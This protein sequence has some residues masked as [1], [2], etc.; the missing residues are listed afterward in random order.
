MNTSRLTNT[1]FQ[2]PN[3]ATHLVHTAMLPF[4]PNCPVCGSAIALDETGIPTLSRAGPFS[5]P[6]GSMSASG[7]VIGGLMGAVLGGPG[8]ALLGALIGGAIGTANETKH[9]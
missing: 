9:E 8:G 4:Q 1:Y 2:C 7:A 3:C 6:K 5:V